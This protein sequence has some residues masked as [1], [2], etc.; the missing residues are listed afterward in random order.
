[1]RELYELIE[2][3][4]KNTGYPGEISGEEFYS[5]VSAE[6]DEQ[7]NGKYLFIIRKLNIYLYNV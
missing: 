3:K 4:I 2:A 1:M 7:D 6:A 5:D